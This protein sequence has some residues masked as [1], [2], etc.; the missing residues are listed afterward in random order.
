VS[1]SRERGKVGCLLLCFIFVCLCFGACVFV[2]V[3]LR[4]GSAVSLPSKPRLSFTS[5][6]ICDGIRKVY[7]MEQATGT[8]VR[9]GAETRWGS[10]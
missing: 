9:E 7:A 10:G 1:S 8:Y 5:Q 6:S 3:R 2:F 4:P